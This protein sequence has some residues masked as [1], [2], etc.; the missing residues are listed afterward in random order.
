MQ[1]FFLA[2]FD[3]F[4]DLTENKLKSSIFIVHFVVTMCSRILTQYAGMP[5]ISRI[6]VYTISM[7]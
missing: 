1:T 3:I 6:E 4:F 2:L 7:N 5:V